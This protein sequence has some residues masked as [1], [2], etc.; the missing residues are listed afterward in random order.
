LEKELNVLYDGEMQAS[1]WR[2]GNDLRD[3]LWRVERDKRNAKRPG[4]KMT[5]AAVD[6]PKTFA[7]GGDFEKAAFEALRTGRIG[8]KFIEDLKA[9]MAEVEETL[10]GR[11]QA[12]VREDGEKC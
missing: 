3:L 2:L 9:A 8:H 5:E 1:L 4:L 10:L 11:K 6:L 7:F 12:P